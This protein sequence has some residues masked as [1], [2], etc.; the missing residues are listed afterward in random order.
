M[1]I[2][3]LLKGM[4]EREAS[5]LYLTVDLPPTFRIHGSTQPVG[6]TPFTN[7]QLENLAIA[8]MRGQQRGDFEEKMLKR[9]WDRILPTCGFPAVHGLCLII[10]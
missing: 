9:S 1:D 7:E 5:D 3:A 6:D 8:L 4:V 10:T 2:K